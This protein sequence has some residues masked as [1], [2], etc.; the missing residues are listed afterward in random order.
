[1]TARFRLDGCSQRQFLYDVLEPGLTPIGARGDF[2][3]ELKGYGYRWLRFVDG[4]AAP[5]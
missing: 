3:V 2:T 5:I 1:V 4:A